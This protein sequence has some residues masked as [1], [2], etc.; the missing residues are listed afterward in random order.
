MIGRNQIG[1]G[2]EFRLGCE[3]FLAS[4]PRWFHTARLG[5][6]ANQAS[7]N[8]SLQSVKELALAAGGRL[9]CIFSPQHGY[10]SEK[11]AN[12]IQSSDWR[13]PDTGI[14]VVSLYSESRE[15]PAE[16]LEAID[17]L[18]I[19]LQDIGTRVYTYTATMGLCLEAAARSGVKAVVLDRPNPINGTEIEGNVVEPAF[20]SFVGRYPVPMRHGLTAGEFA[21]FV[22]AAAD[23]D[24][25]L[26][27]VSMK[28]WRRGCQFDELGLH[29]VYPSPNMPTWETALLYPGMVLLEGT[30]ISEGRGTTM[31]FQLFGAPFLNRRGF[32]EELKKRGL[33]GVTFRPVVYEPAFD[34]Y[35]RQACFGFQIHITDKERFKPYRMGLNLLQALGITHPDLF[36]WLDPPYEYELEKLPIDILIGSDAVRRRVEQGQDIGKIEWSWEQQL[37]EYRE[38]REACL[39]YA[40]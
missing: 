7:V 3:V 15:P 25:D 36:K 37:G 4:P 9:S 35:K 19:D 2:E 33:E 8:K 13:D 20:R 23:V 40:E 17:V 30:N 16:A 14:P 26:D 28:G 18:L 22:C 39:L 27:V 31:P 24:C 32:M 6:L 10:Y 12:M 34:K 1:R 29:W 38:K 11:Q 21:R 5:L